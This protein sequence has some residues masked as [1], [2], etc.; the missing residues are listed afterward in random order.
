MNLTVEPAVVQWPE[1]HYVFVEKI[2]SFQKMAPE[3]WHEAHKLVGA[4]AGHTTIER[5]M[6]L[7]P[8]DQLITE[9]LVPIT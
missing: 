2:G 3:A 1:A 6:S 5:Y 4:L 7:Y 8:E 9:I